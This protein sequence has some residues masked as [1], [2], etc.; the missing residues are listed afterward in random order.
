MIIDDITQYA[1]FTDGKTA[2]VYL[3]LVSIAEGN[4]GYAD[5]TFRTFATDVNLSV[6]ELRTS[7][8][9]LIATHL[10]T[11]LSNCRS[12]RLIVHATQLAT[13]LGAETDTVTHSA[14]H[15]ATHL[16]DCESASFTT[17]ATHSATHS[18]TQQENE[19]KEKE[20]LS[21]VPLSIEKEN[22]EK[23]FG[24]V[25]TREIFFHRLRNEDITGVQAIQMR[26]R[27]SDQNIA[28]LIQEFYL[29]SVHEVYAN[30]QQFYNHFRNFIICKNG[31]YTTNSNNRES[32]SDFIARAARL[33]RYG[34]EPSLF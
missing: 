10:V 24:V 25:D 30:Y 32:S 1:W 13:Q 20:N 22:K 17:R 29:H 8:K 15:S 34:N 7:I 18:A 26:F 27:L 5:I 23:E 2:M 4:N 11:Q 16:T 21:P 19:R 14:T 28:D 9:K 31:R 6:Q 33:A 12:T 3:K